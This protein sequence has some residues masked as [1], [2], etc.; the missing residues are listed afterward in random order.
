MKKTY[1]IPMVDMSPTKKEIMSMLVPWNNMEYIHD[2][3]YS[4]DIPIMSRYIPFTSIY[5]EIGKP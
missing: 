2:G 4:H 5:S 3:W 1:D